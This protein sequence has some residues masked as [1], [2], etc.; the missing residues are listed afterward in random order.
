[1]DNRHPTRAPSQALA[2]Q[3]IRRFVRCSRRIAA[4]LAPLA[5]SLVGL[6]AAGCTTLLGEDF[7]G[8]QSYVSTDP[9]FDAGPEGATEPVPASCSDGQQNDD[10]TDTDCGGKTCLACEPGQ[11]CAWAGDCT[12]SVCTNAVCQSATCSDLQRNGAESD[13]DCGGGLCSACAPN[14]GCSVDSDCQTNFC[15]SGICTDPSC[16][17]GAVDSG[18][19]DTDCGGE[20]CPAC[21]PS[22]HCTTAA[23]CSSGV[24]IEQV[25]QPPTC[26]DGVLNGVETDVDCGGGSCASCALGST[27]AADADCSSTSC[28][29]GRCEQNPC[30]NGV[31]D[32]TETSVDCGGP[33]CGPC[34]DGEACKTAEDCSSAVCTEGV[35][36]LP[37]CNNGARDQDES[38]TDCG[39]TICRPCLAGRACSAGPDCVSGS[40]VAGKCDRSVMVTD[41]DGVTSYGIDATEVTQRSYAAFLAATAGDTSGQA[42][43]CSWNSSFEPSMSGNGCAVDTYAPA[44]SPDLPVTCVDWCDA[45]AYCAWTGMRLCGA[46]GGGPTPYGA[47]DSASQSQWHN[48]CSAGGT[49]TFPYG[50]VLDGSACNASEYG[51]GA[52]VAVAEVTTCHGAIAPLS[53]VRDLSGNAWEW[54]DSCA[55]YKNGNDDCRTRGGSFGTASA[56]CKRDATQR[57]NTA[58]ADVGF[59]CC[60]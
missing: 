4:V 37:L 41:P 46:I 48:A 27:C 58:H 34:R 57:R 59:R 54:E 30:T 55:K 24:C 19:S 28:R 44:T 33:A 22:Q 35:C 23:D 25:C 17:N 7:A 38:D 31:V 2:S 42:S 14:R 1:M 45:T 16:S 52:L 8:Y 43:Y 5:A 15:K 11:G 3:R 12:T 26:G 10:E 39:G 40:C 36:G 29:A 51:A 6:P 53:Q 60:T 56:K 18:E 32:G 50:D 9:A 13:V 49:V 47:F 21:G 20:L